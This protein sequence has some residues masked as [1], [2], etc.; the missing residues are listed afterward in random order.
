MQS[1]RELMG[2]RSSNMAKLMT[3]QVIAHELGKR[4]RPDAI[5]S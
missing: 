1:W 4:L 2:K 5:V 3:P